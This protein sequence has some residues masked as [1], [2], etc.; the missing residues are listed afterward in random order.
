M[1]NIGVPFLTRDKSDSK[2]PAATELR[3][4]ATTAIPLVANLSRTMMVN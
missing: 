4:T 3:I 2:N 1:H